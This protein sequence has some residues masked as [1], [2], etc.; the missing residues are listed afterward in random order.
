MAGIKRDP[1]DMG[2][3]FLLLESICSMYTHR[4][5]WPMLRGYRKKLS[6]FPTRELIRIHDFL[7]GLESGRAPAEFLGGER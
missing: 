4:D 5:N 7:A 6:S 2:L 1:A 3:R